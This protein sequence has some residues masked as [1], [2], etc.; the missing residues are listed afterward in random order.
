MRDS[1]RDQVRELLLEVGVPVTSYAHLTIILDADQE[2]TFQEIARGRTIRRSI[3]VND[4]HTELRVS[5][6]VDFASTAKGERCGIT[7]HAPVKA[8]SL[9][10]YMVAAKELDAA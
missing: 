5:R 8:Q 2:E 1:V 7:V 10:D 9:T 6:F 4:E 3:K